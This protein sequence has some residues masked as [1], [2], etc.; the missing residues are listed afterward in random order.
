VAHRACTIVRKLVLAPTL[1]ILAGLA[2]GCFDDGADS[3]GNPDPA[4]AGNDAPTIS[5]YAPNGARVAEPYTFQPVA[6]DADGD[7]LQFRGDRLPQWMSLDTTS[8]RLTGTPQPGDE[9]TYS[10]ISI[11]V[12]DGWSRAALGPFTI[13]VNQMATGTAT[14]S[15]QA[16]VSNADGSPLTNLA[17]YRIVY[18][19][20]PRDLDQSV[21]IDNPSISTYIVERLSPGTW[22]FAVIAVN[23]VCLESVPS[24]LGSKSIN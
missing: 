18:G 4:P 19:R 24:D 23:S 20:E 16:P 13:T 22:Y 15:W 8:G 7:T 5:G 11:E 2:G 17:G 21:P 9:G 10:G 6:R 3:S 12:S 14:L 1:G